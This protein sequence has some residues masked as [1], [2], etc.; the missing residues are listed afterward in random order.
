MKSS[1]IAIATL[2][3]VCLQ[4]SSAQA[5]SL[6]GGTGSIGSGTTNQALVCQDWVISNAEAKYSATVNTCSV[7]SDNDEPKRRL[8]RLLERIPKPVRKLMKWGSRCFDFL[9]PV[10]VPASFYFEV[11]S[12][13]A[14]YESCLTQAGNSRQNCYTITEGRIAREN[15]TNPA[16]RR[17]QLNAVCDANYKSDIANCENTLALRLSDAF[18]RHF[19]EALPYPAEIIGNV[20]EWV[21]EKLFY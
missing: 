15:P 9:D 1:M 19:L 2:G 6:D 11:E 5:I 13:L 3:L 17:R 10:L 8:D 12:A 7:F 14:E 18:A 16:E 4:A 20:G 21:C